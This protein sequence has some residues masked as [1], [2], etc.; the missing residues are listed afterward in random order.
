MR[1]DIGVVV[2][3]G[4]AVVCCGGLMG[5]SSIVPSML[6]RFVWMASQRR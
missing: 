4:I 3:G 2:V 6:L 1:R 5:G